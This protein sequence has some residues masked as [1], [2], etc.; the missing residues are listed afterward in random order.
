MTALSADPATPAFHLYVC[1]PGLRA[2]SPATCLGGGVTTLTDR[3]AAV[4][5]SV[6]KN[7]ATTPT[8]LSFD[9]QNNQG[10]SKDIVFRS[11]DPNAS[12]DDIVSWISINTLFARMVQ[13]GKLP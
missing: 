6:G 13:A 3:A 11:G 12:F 10:T 9:E 2:A 4:V 8:G 7:A 1:G 5:Y